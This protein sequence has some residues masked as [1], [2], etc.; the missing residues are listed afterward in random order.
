MAAF[1]TCERRFR[2]SW[3]NDLRET[4]FAESMA[5]LEKKRGSRIFIEVNSAD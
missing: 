3:S 4:V 5:A 1:G 2:R